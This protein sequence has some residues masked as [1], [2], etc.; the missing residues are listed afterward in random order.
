MKTLEELAKE[1]FIRFGLRETG[2]EPNW[3]YLH[4]DRKLEW[5]KEVLEIADQVLLSLKEHQ[6]IPAQHNTA[7][8]TSWA[9]GYAQGLK[10]ERV[11]LITQID[12]IHN[13]LL[14]QLQDYK[15]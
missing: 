15:G 14:D 1:L 3:D 7:F 12:D 2:T 6:K 13:D 9:N 4:Q 11:N 5:M 10:D 8:N